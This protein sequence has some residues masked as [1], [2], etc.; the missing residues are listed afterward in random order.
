MSL[1]LVPSAKSLAQEHGVSH[2]TTERALAT[3]KDEGLVIAVVG[4]G[5]Y[6]VH[7]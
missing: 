7:S 5:F 4:K 3:L 1:G 6:T 2:Q